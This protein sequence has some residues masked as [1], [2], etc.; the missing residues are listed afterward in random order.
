MR[1][2]ALV[3]LVGCLAS[4]CSGGGGG[5]SGQSTAGSQLVTPVPE[6][7]EPTDFSKIACGDVGEC[8]TACMVDRPFMGE[9]EL[10]NLL[11]PPSVG[12]ATCKGLIAIDDIQRESNLACLNSPTTEWIDPSIIGTN[13]CITNVSCQSVCHSMFQPESDKAIQNRLGSGGAALRAR[14]RNQLIIRQLEAC[15]EAPIAYVVAD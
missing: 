13:T 7:V 15:L 2:L 6:F 5:A 14:H 11:C 3:L 8:A 1:N 10:R 4:A 9:S 12:E